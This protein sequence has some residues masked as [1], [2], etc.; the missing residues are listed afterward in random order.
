MVIMLLWRALAR[1][2]QLP[3][4]AVLTQGS[5]VNHRFQLDFIPKKNYF[6]N[7][8]MIMHTILKASDLINH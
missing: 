2:R 6:G 1:A 5:V 7:A 4:N 8:I 3:S